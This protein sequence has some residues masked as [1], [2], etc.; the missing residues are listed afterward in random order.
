MKDV[1]LLFVTKKG[2]ALQ[3]LTKNILFLALCRMIQPTFHLPLFLSKA[4]AFADS[5]CRDR[6]TYEIKG[7]F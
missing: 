3:S 7:A 1:M 5:Y 6:V 2:F 4:A